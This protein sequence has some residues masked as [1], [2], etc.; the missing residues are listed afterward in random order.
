MPRLKRQ[1]G[2]GQPDGPPDFFADFQ[3]I[4]ATKTTFPERSQDTITINTKGI[5]SISGNLGERLCDPRTQ[6]GNVT[7]HYD[8]KS[9]RVAIRAVS[10][11]PHGSVPI[12][13]QK[14]SRY[15]FNGRQVFKAMEDLFKIRVFPNELVTIEAEW[16]E[17][18]ERGVPGAV[19]FHL[20]EYAD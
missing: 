20:P 13:K 3:F 7:I 1:D 16:V 17:W 15:K 6:K 18:G 11:D 14:G 10:D 19:I 2:I 5:V 9:G 12:S 8:A 4:P